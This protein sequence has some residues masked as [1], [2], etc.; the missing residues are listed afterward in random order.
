MKVRSSHTAVLIA[1][2]LVL[3]SQEA[4][5]AQLSSQF[6]TVF[7]TILRDRMQKS[8]GEHK[9][10]Y[11]EAAAE[12]DSALVP[13]L[14][15]LV[16]SNLSSFPLS[17]TT[18]GI[19]FDF[20]GGELVSVQEGAGP[21]FADRATT[22]GKGNINVGVNATYLDLNRIRGLATE[23]IRFTFTHKD[24]NND[25]LLGGTDVDGATEADYIDVTMGLNLTASIFALYGT[26][27]ITRN[28]DVGVAVPFISIHMHG[29]ARAVINSY[30]YA[31]YQSASHF[32]GQS[33][34]APILET[35][36]GYD[37]SATGV[38]DV[39][40]RL[41]YCFLKGSGLD[42]GL[43]ADVRL[44]TGK[45]EDFFGSGKTNALIAA[46]LSKKMG[47]FSWHLNAGYELRNTEYESDRVVLKGGFDHRILKGLTFAADF[48]GTF[49]TDRSKTVKLFPGT[50]SIVEY[51][52]LGGQSIKSIELSNVPDRE[53]DNLYDLS[54]GFKF[55][56][57]EGFLVLLNMLVPLNNGGLRSPVATTIGISMNF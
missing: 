23:Q 12:A 56:P 7:Q 45:K 47:D 28:L 38:G 22:V 9:T 13:A 49:D 26:W 19:S 32:F 37:R 18:P 21:V 4:A 51:G 34:D 50:A 57:S 35:N 8:T 29:T 15:G 5:Q 27:G 53:N 16:V 14:N 3:C 54:A 17:S 44:P 31:R 39:A 10:H 43:L 41:K 1:I 40:V 48:L 46:L 2:L 6:S 42:L 55:S 11:F 20:S 30:S 24:V 36:V 33:S 52:R 25:G